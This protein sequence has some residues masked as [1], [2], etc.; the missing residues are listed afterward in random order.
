MV[1]CQTSAAVGW[2]ARDGAGRC[3]CHVSLHG[4]KELHAVVDA[5]NLASIRLL[6]ALGFSESA[7]TL[8]PAVEQFR[9]VLLAS[10]HAPTIRTARPDDAP[11]LRQIHC[12]AFGRPAEA[13]L[14]AAL[15]AEGYV[16]VRW[17]PRWR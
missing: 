5:P 9:F 1:C 12:A 15:Y 7:P 14:V 6:R 4:Q 16:V 17:S 11:S 2:P 8:G 10:R 3:R 13:D